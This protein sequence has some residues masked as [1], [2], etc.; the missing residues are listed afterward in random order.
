MSKIAVASKTYGRT[1]IDM[2]GVGY[3]LAFEKDHD[4]NRCVRLVFHTHVLGADPEATEGEPL[5]LRLGRDFI[6]KITEALKNVPEQTPWEP[7][8]GASQPAGEPMADVAEWEFPDGPSE[9][10]DVVVFD[11]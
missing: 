7:P 2:T 9:D 11:G 8:H 4:G 10:A 1:E 6:T 3:T 5:T